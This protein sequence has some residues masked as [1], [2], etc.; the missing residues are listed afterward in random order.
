M[1]VKLA[2]IFAGLVA[3]MLSAS[4]AAVV[5]P[6][7]GVDINVG[8]P[9]GTAPSGPYDG[10]VIE[11]PPGD[12]ETIWFH[13]VHDGGLWH[14]NE[15]NIDFLID[16]SGLDPPSWGEV[17]F[18]HAQTSIEYTGCIWYKLADIQIDGPPCTY[19]QIQVNLDF[20]ATGGQHSTTITKHIIPEP[21]SMLLMGTVMVAFLLRKRRC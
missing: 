4:T 7:G 12:I 13:V 6:S 8:N 2:V 11:V 20:G 16:P 19:F 18:E 14:L 21:T 15:W 3:L 1:R 10:S 17:I 5:G 9:D